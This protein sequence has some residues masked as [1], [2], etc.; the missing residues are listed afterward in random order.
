MGRL[1]AGPAR[2]GLGG[3][4]QP[5]AGLAGSR[6][7]GR[8]RAWRGRSGRRYTFSVFPLG[9][10]LDHLPVDGDAVVIAVAR[11][12]DGTRRKLW[13]E[14]TGRDPNDLFRSARLRAL[15]ARPDCEL[16]LHLLA[17]TPADRRA[18]VDDLRDPAV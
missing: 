5:L 1:A 6:L 4:D 13:V 8:F 9:C 18:L 16:H 17:A 2:A 10:G 11:Q 7:E 15:A 14:A 3:H 12:A